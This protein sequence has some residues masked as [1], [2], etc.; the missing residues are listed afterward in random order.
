[1]INLYAP[2]GDFCGAGT[3]AKS[4]W[5][6]TEMRGQDHEEGM[7]VSGKTD[8]LTDFGNMQPEWANKVFPDYFFHSPNG[9]SSRELFPLWPCHI[10]FL[11]FCQQLVKKKRRHGKGQLF[12][13]SLFNF[14]QLVK[15]KIKFIAR[16]LAAEGGGGLSPEKG[17]LIGPTRVRVKISLRSWP[18]SKAR[19]MHVGM[20][21]WAKSGDRKSLPH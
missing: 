12:L 16:Q 2:G 21:G 1:M 11:A 7:V 3:K 20:E 4:V 6:V 18:N 15:S 17:W 19:P 10:N 14:L 13:P 5:H 8:G 9:F